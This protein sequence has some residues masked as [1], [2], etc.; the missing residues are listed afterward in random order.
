MLSEDVESIDAETTEAFRERYESELRAVIESVGVET[1][2]TETDLE[3]ETVEALQPGESPTVTLSKAA[4]VL[5]EAGN[6]PGAETIIAEAREVLLLGMS[7]A[8]LDVESVAS[9]LDF[10]LDPK[11]IQAKIEGRQPMTIAFHAL[12]QRRA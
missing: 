3:R 8:I 1:A 2:V 4:S 12:I 7:T 6:R 5:T 9:Q 10:G 11:E